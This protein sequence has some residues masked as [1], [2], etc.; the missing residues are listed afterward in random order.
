MA[1]MCG[2]KERLLASS[3]LWISF[4]VQ[5]VLSSEEVYS[6]KSYRTAEILCRH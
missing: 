6:K 1:Y 2:K 5:T 3:A 4:L